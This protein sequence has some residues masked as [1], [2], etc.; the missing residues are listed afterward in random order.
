MSAAF[1]IDC[2]VAIAWLFK[3]EGT[4]QT[5][6]LLTRLETESALVPAWWFLELA[7]VMAVAERRGRI[8]PG[9]S[10]EFISQLIRLDV[11]IDVE[12]P[13]RVFDYILPL[14][15]AHGLTS[16]DAMYLDVALRRQ[17]PLATLDEQLRKAAL[18]EGA[19]LLGQ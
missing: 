16:Y 5:A 15:R 2:S 12:S 9:E 14:C 11:E 18:K 1:V 4:T 7:N 19:E 17:L 6:Q 13:G 3:D 10:A 8:S